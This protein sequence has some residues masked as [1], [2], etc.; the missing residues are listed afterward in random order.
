MIPVSK[1]K[2]V[3]L[4]TIALKL[5]NNERILSELANGD[6]VIR[7]EQLSSKIPSL[8]SLG[9][10][11]LIQ[12]RATEIGNTYLIPTIYQK[13]DRCVISL[14]DINATISDDFVIGEW[15]A[16][17]VNRAII[18][19][20]K[21]EV[22][23]N[24][25]IVFTDYAFESIQIEHGN[26][27]EGEGIETLDHRWLK[28]A[29]EIELRLHTLP[30]DVVLTITGESDR[31][32]KKFNTLLVDI[33]DSDHQLYKNVITNA[34]LRQLIAD[35]C[36]QFKIK[37]V[38]IVHVKNPKAKNKNDKIRATHKVLIEPLDGTDFADF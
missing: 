7:A 1:E 35:G 18:I 8:K 13:D 36:K 3:N 15:K 6:Q 27:L 9:N 19:D 14:P 29:P 24:A 33:V 38:E 11:P 34:D 10:M 20:K 12:L 30:L 25:G 4:Q 23:I 17:D 28:P 26:R 16:G 32:S 22:A 31:R 37:S 5:L 21:S 2:P